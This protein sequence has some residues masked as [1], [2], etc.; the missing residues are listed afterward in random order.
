MSKN[1][2]AQ[3]KAS[4]MPKIDISG[5]GEAMK[6]AAH[7]V[8]ID[9]ISVLGGL[10]VGAGA[11]G[12]V[13]A[14][15]NCVDKVYGTIVPQTV[16]VKRHRF[17]KEKTMSESAF[18]AE[19]RKGKKFHSG[20]SNRLSATE[21]YQKALGTGAAAVGWGVTAAA[22]VY[23]R[24]TLKDKDKPYIILDGGNDIRDDEDFE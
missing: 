10:L 20:R 13:H 23:A 15:A 19:V 24:D 9:T 8:A 2:K 17:S 11:Q 12:L 22:T 5:I 6:S 3:V 7:E 21:G 16:T 4:K 14:G 18:I 1:T